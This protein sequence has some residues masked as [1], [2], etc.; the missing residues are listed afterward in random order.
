VCVYIYIYIYKSR[1]EKSEAK[2]HISTPSQIHLLTHRLFFSRITT[3]NSLLLLSVPML[4]NN[5]KRK[6]RYITLKRKKILWQQILSMENQT[7]T[8]SLL[9]FLFLPL[10]DQ[11]STPLLKLPSLELMSAP[12]KV[13]ITSK[14]QLPKSHLFITFFFFFGLFQLKIW[15][16]FWLWIWQDCWEWSL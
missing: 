5:W 4:V 2:F 3:C 1:K 12:L 16:F 8:T 6:P 13:L 10:K 11:M 14:T 7:T 9:P 15:I